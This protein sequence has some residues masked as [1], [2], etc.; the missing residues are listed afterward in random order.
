MYRDPDRGF[1]VWHRT[2]IVSPTGGGLWVPNIND[3]VFDPV[4]GFFIVTEV[5]ITTGYS[6]LAAWHPP[7]QPEVM[8]PQDVL[9]GAGPGYPSE[10]YR[11]FL[12]TSVT[13]HTFT[14]D[15]R[16]RFYGSMVQYYKVFLGSDIS[17]EHGVVVSTFFD[18]S[19]NFLGTSVPVE[20][21]EIPGAV[22][23][24][25]RAP[26]PGYCNRQLDDGELVTLVAYADDASVVSIAQLVVKN[27]AAIRQHDSSKRYIQGIAIESPFL[28]ESDPSL[29]KFPINVPV[30][31]LPMTGVVHYS[32]GTKYRLAI[33]GNKFSLFGFQ[34]YVATV[35]GQTF[36]LLLN[37]N[38]SIDEVSYNVIP[39]ANNTLTRP[40]YAQ[41]TEANGAYSVKLFMFPVWINPQVGYRLEYWL[42]NLDRQ[43]FYNATPYVELGINSAPFN[44]TDYGVTQTITVA[45]DLNRVDGQFL[46]VRHVQ[47]FQIALIAPGP[48]ANWQ[49]SFRPD[50]QG[51]YG[52]DLIADVELI[53]TNYWHLRLA[54]GFPSQ[55]LW[56]TNM[57][58]AIEPLYNPDSEVEAPRPTH[59]RVVFLH[60]QYEMDVNQW[61]ETLV[62]NNDLADGELVYL[63]WITRLPGVG[64]LQLGISALPVKRRNM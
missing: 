58:Q 33:D 56:L 26:Q 8:P 55:E 28:S 25:I 42:Y 59:V 15:S 18:P 54:N 64:D 53:D 45:V 12:D 2:E 32:D 21:V 10:S 24:T 43:T 41:T 35:V 16:L 47:T 17:E 11:M 37:Y 19:M 9:L 31:S 34:N 39:T 40:Y 3:M 6:T 52:R 20:A 46:P 63:Q 49:V 13:P 22:Q 48:E 29:I 36:D 27:T 44:P 7:A 60:N 50:Q 62:V 61:N 38:L 14:P 1:R 57:Y 4:Q 5:D 23:T 51:S 30:E